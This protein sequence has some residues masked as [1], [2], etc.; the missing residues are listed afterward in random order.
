MKGSHRLPDASA[1]RL[2]VGFWTAQEFTHITSVIV[3]ALHPLF[4]GFRAHDEKSSRLFSPSLFVHDAVQPNGHFGSLT[5]P[6]GHKE[7]DLDIATVA[8]GELSVNPQRKN[9]RE[10]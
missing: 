4:I 10:K 5:P 1:E 7:P 3:L 6:I 8:W 2:P 9:L